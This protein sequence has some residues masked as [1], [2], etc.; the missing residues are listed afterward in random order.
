M[1]AGRKDAARRSE[2][3]RQVAGEAFHLFSAHIT[4]VRTHGC[5]MRGLFPFFSL[6]GCAPEAAAP[7]SRIEGR[8]NDAAVNHT[9]SSTQH[10]TRICL[11]SV[12]SLVGE[13]LW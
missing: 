1:T 12:A 9:D 4:P 2:D 11:I 5:K 13:A 10:P 7:I 3:V 6:G 8:R